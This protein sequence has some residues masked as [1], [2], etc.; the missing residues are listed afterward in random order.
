M[1]TPE[2][3]YIPTHIEIEKIEIKSN[4]DLLHRTKLSQEGKTIIFT[5]KR[6]KPAFKSAIS[7]HF[8]PCSVLAE[9]KICLEI[10]PESIV[11]AY[12]EKISKE[13]TK[14]NKNAA[15]ARLITP[16]LHID[17]ENDAPFLRTVNVVLPL[18]GDVT[19]KSGET[20]I[21]VP[22]KLT[23]TEGTVKVAAIKFSPVAVAEVNKILRPLKLDKDFNYSFDE[24]G[25]Y[26]LSEQLENHHFRM[27]LRK[28]SDWQEHR[29]FRMDESKWLILVISPRRIQPGD[30]DT[31]VEAHLRG[32]HFPLKLWLLQGV[33]P[34]FK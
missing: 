25:V 31:K 9:E 11:K 3:S 34:V 8:P 30:I 10:I 20:K 14:E 21:A 27:D 5:D 6:I 1:S 12:N 17:R 33:R 32:I 7:V 23:V 28:F 19:Y 16:I 4:A 22:G 15:K 2:T 24:L 26:L 13:K 29:R 18:L